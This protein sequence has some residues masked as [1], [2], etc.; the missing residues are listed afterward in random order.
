[1]HWS[2]VSIIAAVGIAAA[3]GGAWWL[4][5]R[6]PKRQVERFR[7]TIRDPKARADVEDNFRKTITQVFGGIVVLFGGA[8]ALIGAG[9]ANYG[10][11]QTFGL[12]QIRRAAVTKRPT[13]YSLAIRSQ[14]VSCN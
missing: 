14:A 10:T 7:L 6:F 1:M 4:W 8:A 13:T 5:W 11:Q 2:I 9:L 3:F 12:Q